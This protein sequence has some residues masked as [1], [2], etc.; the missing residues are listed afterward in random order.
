[1]YFWNTTALADDLKARRV[2]QRDKMIYLLVPI[3]L[4]VAS[5]FL[6]I[7]PHETRLLTLVE[8]VLAIVVTIGGILLCYQANRRGDDEEFLDR[9]ICLGWPLAIRMLVLSI[10]LAFLLQVGSCM[11]GFSDIPAVNDPVAKEPTTPSPFEDIGRIVFIFIVVSGLFWRLRHHM[12]RV[13]GAAGGADGDR[14]D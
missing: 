9:F 7:E 11:I 3:T 13:S 1:M 12:L 10:P 6:P 4:S 2:P 5:E 8:F 14:I